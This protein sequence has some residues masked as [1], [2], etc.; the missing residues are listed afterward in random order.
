[1]REKRQNW[2]IRVQQA[3]HPPEHSSAPNRRYAAIARDQY[4]AGTHHP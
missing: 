4:P 3:G 1:M 2:M